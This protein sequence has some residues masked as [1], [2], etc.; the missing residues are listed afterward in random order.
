MR[1][2]GPAALAVVILGACGGEPPEGLGGFDLELTQSQVMEE[3]GGRDGFTCRLRATR[4]KVTICG[5][6]T[7]EGPVEVWVQGDSTARITLR[8]EGTGEEG[9]RAV[10]GMAGDFGEPAW[11]DRPYPPQSQPPESY[12]TLWVDED[13]TRSVA[14]ICRGTGLEPP[15]SVE[16]KPTSPTQ[17]LA[18]LDTL[19]GIRR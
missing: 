3:A 10:R 7:A 2:V 8:K 6:P 15:C 14:L 13:T 18:Q 12:H 9:R 19:L 5:G 4:P 16:L 11:R 1:P 17:L